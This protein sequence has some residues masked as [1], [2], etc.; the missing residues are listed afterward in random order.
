MNNSLKTEIT[1]TKTKKNVFKLLIL[2]FLLTAIGCVGI[3][4]FNQ[5]NP[6]VMN[7]TISSARSLEDDFSLITTEEPLFSFPPL[8]SPDAEPQEVFIKIANQGQIAVDASLL[9]IVTRDDLFDVV[10]FEI[11][12]TINP[13]TLFLT[14]SQFQD[15]SIYFRSILP[16]TEFIFRLLVGLDQDKI[17]N[18]LN[19]DADDPR[20]PLTFAFN[21]SIGIVQSE[22]T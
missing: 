13:N 19:I 5:D 8:V 15:E 9:L 16:N 3:G 2:L 17:T 18:D 14:A 4:I 11:E 10:E 22:S 20:F 6:G 1:Q 21:L 12:N 7:V